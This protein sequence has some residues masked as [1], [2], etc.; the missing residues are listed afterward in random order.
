VGGRFRSCAS[1]FFHRSIFSAALT[2][3]YQQHN[4]ILW[5]HGVS[6]FVWCQQSLVFTQ[7]N[8]EDAMDHGR[9]KKLIKIADDQDGGWVSVSSST[10]S[11][12]VVPDK[13]P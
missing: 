11:T 8:R 5:T 7:K 3:N 1:F 6:G 10:R 9:Q 4:R 2:N 12:R 13:R